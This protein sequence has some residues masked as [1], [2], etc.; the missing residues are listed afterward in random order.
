M[1]NLFQVLALYQ[2]TLTLFEAL[3]LFNELSVLD[4]LIM[5]NDLI[6]KKVLLDYRNNFYFTLF[7]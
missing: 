1:V 7:L 5:F 3:H 4:N 6:G 2:S